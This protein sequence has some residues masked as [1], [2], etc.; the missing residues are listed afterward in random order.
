MKSLASPLGQLDD[1]D[2]IAD[3]NVVRV[4]GGEEDELVLPVITGV[5]D[6]V[7]KG[8]ATVD[9]IHEHVKLIQ[10]PEGW[11]HGVPESQD[12]RHA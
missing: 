11:S 3:A 4:E 12:E 7:L 2:V 9:S 1:L 5:V 8:D 10:N 6:D